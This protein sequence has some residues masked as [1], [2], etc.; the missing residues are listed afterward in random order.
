MN[1]SVTYERKAQ[2]VELP[3]SFDKLLIQNIP[4]VNNAVLQLLGA[5]LIN[6]ADDNIIQQRKSNIFTLYIYTSRANA[7]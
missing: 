6:E 7:L 3:S 1:G 4:F 2:C 5:T